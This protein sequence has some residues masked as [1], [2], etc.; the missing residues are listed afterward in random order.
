MNYNYITNEDCLDLLKRDLEYDYVIFGPPDFDEIGLKTDSEGIFLYEQFLLAR[1]KLLNPKNNVVTI[2][3]RNRK[4]NGTVLVKDEIMRRLMGTCGY[5]LK[6][7]KIWIRSYKANLYRFNQTHIQTFSRGKIFAPRALSLP[8]AFYFEVQPIEG[9]KDNFPPEL[10]DDF[11][12]VYCPNGGI[13]MDPFVGSGSTCIA[14]LN[15]DR[16]YLGAE[17]VKEVYDLAQMRIGQL[18]SLYQ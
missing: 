6:S 15:C 16:K 10:V 7:Q 12:D 5:K 13:V 2:I 14:A 3:Q 4:T 18:T 1:M 11:I 9:Y 8:D 17:I